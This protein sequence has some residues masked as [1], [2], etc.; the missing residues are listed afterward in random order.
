M[1]ITYEILDDYR[2]IVT[3]HMGITSDEEFLSKYRELYADEKFD[4]SYNQLVDLR[5]AD[6]RNRSTAALRSLAD[7][8]NMHYGGTG[9]RPRTVV[10]AP[11]ALSFGL[12]RIYEAFVSTVPGELKVFQSVEAAL[13]WL[14][15]PTDL[16]A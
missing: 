12:S 16:L 3:T 8:V 2:L 15:L 1:A 6:S 10:I 9:L 11:A 7:I 13:A 4:F 5:R 14:R